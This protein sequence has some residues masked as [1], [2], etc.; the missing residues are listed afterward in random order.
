MENT[1]KSRQRRDY[2]HY[3]GKV[4]HGSEITCTS[5]RTFDVYRIRTPAI[6]KSVLRQRQLFYRGVHVSH[7]CTRA[8][9]IYFQSYC[10][11]DSR[12]YKRGIGL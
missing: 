9:T 11:A 2:R 1:L 5:Y 10:L 7:L 12:N 8:P 4:R 6:S 3:V